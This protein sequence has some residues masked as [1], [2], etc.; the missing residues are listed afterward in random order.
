MFEWEKADRK[1]VAE[2]L[3][4]RETLM[5]SRQLYHSTSTS[6]PQENLFTAYAVDA[7]AL[8]VRARTPR[9]NINLDSLVN[10]VHGV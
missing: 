6:L 3:A 2:I 1:F 10:T 4:A 8:Q 7:S 5:N 9:T